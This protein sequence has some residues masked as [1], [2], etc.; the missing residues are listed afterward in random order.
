MKRLILCLVFFS[1]CLISCQRGGESLSIWWGSWKDYTLTQLASNNVD[2]YLQKEEQLDLLYL[3]D[4]LRRAK[5]CGERQTLIED[6]K[7]LRLFGKQYDL[8]R[9][10]LFDL[11]FNYNYEKALVDA[12]RT[13][14]EN[15]AFT[16]VGTWKTK[17]SIAQINRMIDQISK[18]YPSEY[19]D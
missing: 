12:F 8:P 16:V 10:Y 7:T 4:D 1:S 2:S 19:V 17:F 9:G 5:S 14:L 11:L 13:D 15:I 6:N 18:C 3:F